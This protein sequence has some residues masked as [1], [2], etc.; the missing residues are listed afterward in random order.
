MNNLLCTCSVHTIECWTCFVNA[1]GCW[2]C[3]IVGITGVLFLLT[4]LLK[5]FLRENAKKNLC[6]REFENKKNWET[7][8]SGLRYWEE[9]K[10]KEGV[11]NNEVDNNKESEEKNNEIKLAKLKDCYQ[12]L[13]IKLLMM[14]GHKNITADK[15]Q[16]I[17]NEINLICAEIDK[18]VK[19][20]V[21]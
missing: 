7:F 14:S 13:L 19:E 4:Q 2:T 10:K 12:R 16:M 8:V 18:E 6:K 11:Q 5:E 1:I 3:C 21:K 17:D 20:M 15:I 9:K